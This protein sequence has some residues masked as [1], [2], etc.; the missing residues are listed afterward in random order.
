MSPSGFS[1]AADLTELVEP[2]CVLARRWLA[3]ARGESPLFERRASAQLAGLVQDRGGSELSIRFVDGVIR[4]ESMTVAARELG[5]LTEDTSAFLSPADRALLSFSA[6]VA[7]STPGLVVRVAR[8]RWRQLVGHLVFDADPQT[9]TRRLRLAR[10]DGFR[11]NLNMLGGAVLGNRG[12]DERLRRTIDLLGIPGAD[13]VSLNVS[14]LTSRTSYWSLSDTAAEVVERLRGVFRVAAAKN[15]FINLD[16]EEYR[17]LELTL[18]VFTTIL[19]EPEFAH[20]SAGLALQSYLPDACA[21]L[22]AV[23]DFAQRRH[24]AGGAPV[25]VRLVKGANLAMERVEAELRGWALAPYAT[26]DQTD[27]NYLALVDR[28]MSQDHG[29]GFRVGI[30]THNLYDVALAYL[31]ARGRGVADQVDMEMLQG[32]APAK[33]R[34]VRDTVGRII[35]YTPVVPRDQFELASTYIIRRLEENAQPE[36]FLNALFGDR[37][38][39]QEARFRAAVDGMRSV[40]TERHRSPQRPPAPPRFANTTDSDPSLPEVRDWA[41]ALVETV[42]EPP[43][44]PVLA[45]AAAVDDVVA[46]GRAAGAAWSRRT[47]RERGDILRRVADAVE[48]RRG[49]L[50]TAM[51]TESAKTVGDA[52]P[53]V[54]EAVDFARWYADRAADLDT[55]PL[56]TDGL[57][58]TPHTLTVLLPPWTFPVS[59]PAGGVFA[60]LAAGSAA[61]VQPAAQVSCCAE[62]LLEAVRAAGV[63]EDVV[64]VVRVTDP[65]VTDTLTAHDGVDGVVLSG[66]AKDADHFISLRAGR[67]GG[68]GV[69]AEISG[70]NA[71]VITDA[72]DIDQ[73]VTDLV[74]CA[75]GHAGQNGSAASLAILVG[76][77]GS[78]PRFREQ[79]VDAV[80]SLRVGWSRD[81]GV[82]MGPLIAEP[83]EHQWRAL[84]E[85]DPGESWLIEPKPLDDSGG[86]WSP[87]IRAGVQPGSWFH[88]TQLLGPVLGIMHATDLDE[89]IRWQNDVASGLS[90]GLHSLDRDEIA[91]W[92]ARVDIGN[93]YVNRHITGTLVGRQPFGGWKAS[94]VGPGAKTGGPDYVAQLGVWSETRLPALGLDVDGAAASALGDFRAML[95]DPAD[96]AW[97]G[98]AARSDALSWDHVLGRSVDTADLV[99]EENLLQ[100][101]PVPLVV[102]GLAGSRLVEVARVVLAAL[103]AQTPV[104]VSVAPEVTYADLL[105]GHVWL[106]AVRVESDLD[107]AEALAGERVRVVGPEAQAVADQL[108][109]PGVIALGGPVLANGRR[110]LLSV[111]RER[112]ISRTRHRFGH[113]LR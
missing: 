7:T 85:L 12:A 87:G 98:A 95:N 101:V 56:L 19:A 31:L 59:I 26:K 64:Q 53:E 25:K 76:D 55:D 51:V 40:S 29:P 107:F 21:A 39:E 110:E 37:M 88:R 22:D 36:N 6:A 86:L 83:D 50:I 70:K 4:P 90:G 78:S 93:A 54:S 99:A 2:A 94:V 113:L 11:L 106:P 28:A 34:A 17:D 47:A 41:A 82:T 63:P 84:T 89:A 104:V 5:R 92:L 112:T 14:A 3:P 91:R 49:A 105:N 79:L 10:R 75:F 15:A 71:F 30:G 73:A 20:L 27:A 66:P 62:I 69:V 45:D 38:E 48:D 60:A 8:Q 1:E 80:S 102:R 74:R 33:T 43:R 46:K 65:T 100:W 57:A 13:H 81:L 68:H 72:A 32:W 109:A 111:V 77:I 23:I 67:V 42:P 35:L 9:L 108:S 96:R 97:L 24:D 18:E 16:V 52:D 44:A 103:R 61:V 58:F